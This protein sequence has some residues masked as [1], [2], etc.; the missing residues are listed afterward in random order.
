MEANTLRVYPDRYG[1]AT[2]LVD[3]E[4]WEHLR[5]LTKCYQLLIDGTL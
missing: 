4:I 1:Y 2:C 3:Y 5:R